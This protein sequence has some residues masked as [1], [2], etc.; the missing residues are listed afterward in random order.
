MLFRFL[1][2]DYNLLGLLTPLSSFV[3]RSNQSS[4]NLSGKISNKT[5]PFKNSHSVLFFVG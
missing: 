1:D 5:I 3:A 2:E 4:R